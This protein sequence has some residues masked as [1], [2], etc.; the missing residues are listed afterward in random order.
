MQTIYHLDS[1]A[2]REGSHGRNLARELVAKLAAKTPSHVL[3]R[4]VSQGL[5]FL[6]PA[7][8]D[9]LYIPRAQ[10]TD[11]QRQAL[12]LSDQIV[13]EITKADVLVL[14]APIYN[15]GPPASVKA[16]ADLVARK[17]LTFRYAEHGPVGLLK[18]KKA[19]VIV[20]SGGVP[21]GSPVDHLSPW[22]KTFLG[23]IGIT[24]VTIVPA[25]QLV[26]NEA[27]SIAKARAQIEAFALSS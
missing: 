16:W 25:D 17:D 11:P 26:R 1:S 5:E 24:D 14:S 15:F 13:E 2:R 10:Q 22:I 20:T 3:Y 23:F 21:I 6:T 27:Q 4:D 7:A 12:Q 18:D 19:F 9:G 8:L